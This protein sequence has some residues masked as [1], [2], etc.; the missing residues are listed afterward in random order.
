[1]GEE[2]ILLV[3]VKYCFC[4]GLRDIGT[5]ICLVSMKYSVLS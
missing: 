3:E 4:G 2:D 5:E 1:M